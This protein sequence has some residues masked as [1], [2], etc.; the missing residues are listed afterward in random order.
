VR[1]LIAFVSRL[2]PV[3]WQTRYG[4]EIQALLE[5]VRLGLAS[6]HT[7]GFSALMPLGIGDQWNGKPG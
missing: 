6:P 4:I 2:Y 7:P 3:A 1:R 5:D